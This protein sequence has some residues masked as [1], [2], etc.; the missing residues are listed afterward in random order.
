LLGV[1]VL[2]ASTP[3]VEAQ[4]ERLVLAFYYAWYSRDAW[5]AGQLSDQPAQPYDSRD[6]AAIQ[7][8][9]SQAK[10]AGIDAFV[11][12]WYGPSSGVN[13]MTEANFAA[14]LDVAQA[15]G[16]R[17]AVDIEVT[18]PFFGS[19]GDVQNALA[20][21]LSGHT[22]HPAYLKVN[23]RPVV[24]FWRQQRFSVDNWVAMRKQVDPDRASIWIAEGTDPSYLRVFDGIHW[25]SVA[26]SADPVTSLTNYAG[27]VRKTSQD[28]G[29]FRYWVAPV[30]P[31]Y[32]DTRLRGAGG[33]VR[34]RDNG[35]Y[36]RATF[37]GAARSGAD[38]IIVTSFNEWP[39]GSAIEPS[40]SYG[41]TYLNLTRELA[42]AYRAG[43]IVAPTVAPAPPSTPTPIAANVAQAASLPTATARPTSTAS[44]MPS[45][46]PTWTASPTITPTPTAAASATLLPMVEPTDTPAPTATPSPLLPFGDVP[47]GTWLGV[48]IG[49]VLTGA[50]LGGIMARRARR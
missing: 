16:F 17:A 36:Y 20:T 44:A 35:N 21:L 27:K 13:N 39:E 9:V 30:M 12:S 14:L 29:G 50:L 15:T 28:L 18:G 7:R 22:K 47:F 49:A 6:R 19:A 32:D 45:P 34:P 43:A 37:A 48:G 8:H 41:D 4:N 1:I 31:G 40:V 10:S 26:W 5:G 23:G 3:V 46:S 38:W 33:L 2:S 25:Y 11:Q 24:F 42:A